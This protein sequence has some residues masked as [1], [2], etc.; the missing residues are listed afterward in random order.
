MLVDYNVIDKYIFVLRNKDLYSKNPFLI[1][2]VNVFFKR[3]INQTKQ[4]WIFFQLE[5][6]SVL[7]EF[8]QSDISNNSLMR[9]IQ[10]KVA[11]TNSAK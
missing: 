5:T 10:S 4:T 2:A 9:G 8:V 11:H 3:I 6:L 7:N 1:K